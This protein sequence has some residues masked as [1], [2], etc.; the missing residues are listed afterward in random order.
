VVP[1]KTQTLEGL[2]VGDAGYVLEE[3]S[4]LGAVRAAPAHDERGVEKHEA[5]YEWGTAAPFQ[6]R[7]PHRDRVGSSERAVSVSLSPGPGN[8][9]IIP[10]LLL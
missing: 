2:F 6:G 3:R 1:E 7:K 4:V 10:S 5:G 9:L 8:D